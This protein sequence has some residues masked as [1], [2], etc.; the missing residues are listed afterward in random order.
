MLNDFIEVASQRAH[1]F[2]DLAASLSF[3]LKSFS[4]LLQLI[5]QFGGNPEKL[6]TKLSGFLISCAMPAVSSLER[7]QFLCL[8]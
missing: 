8:D 4:S 2:G 7:G 5:N 3:R 6:L 1:Q